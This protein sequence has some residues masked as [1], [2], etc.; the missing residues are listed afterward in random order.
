VTRGIGATETKAATQIASI[1]AV[2][3]WRYTRR[4]NERLSSAVLTRHP[5]LIRCPL[6]QASVRAADQRGPRTGGAFLSV[7]IGAPMLPRFGMTH[8][9]S[10]Q[11]PVAQC[12][13]NGCQ[14]VI[15]RGIEPQRMPFGVDLELAVNLNGQPIDFDGVN[16]IELTQ[17][18]LTG[19][20]HEQCR[21]RKGW[22]VGV[23]TRK[24]ERDDLLHE[25]VCFTRLLD[26]V[27]EQFAAKGGTRVGAGKRPPH[28]T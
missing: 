20:R 28:G 15:R 13:A 8:R 25:H 22:P 5:F 17:T 11:Q 12:G 7:R 16:F 1:T 19:V 6:D 10:A 27:V 9:A 2:R 23:R 21:L 3:A 18:H 14:L 26:R 4:I 24:Y